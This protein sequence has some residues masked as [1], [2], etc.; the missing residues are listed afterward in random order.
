MQ[1]G[2]SILLRAF[3][4][5]IY[6]KAM[7]S[8]WSGIVK[9]EF[10][11]WFRLSVISSTGLLN[12]NVLFNA[13]WKSEANINV[14]LR[15]IKGS[16][17]IFRIQTLTASWFKK[18][19]LVS[20]KNHFGRSLPDKLYFHQ[21]RNFKMTL[22]GSAMLIW[23]SRMYFI[24]YLIGYHTNFQDKLI[25]TTIMIICYVVLLTTHPQEVVNDIE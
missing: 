1:L 12:M 5:G 19:N 21:S 13:G 11:L 3:E 2:L 20:N 22:Q 25:S 16:F 9:M 4:M 7:N 17:K 18:L 8:A 23:I 24:I 14:R 15:S 6:R 10:F